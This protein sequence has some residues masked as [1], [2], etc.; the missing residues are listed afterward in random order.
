MNKLFVHASN[1]KGYEKFTGAGYK[2]ILTDRNW[3]DFGYYTLHE[4]FLIMPEGIDNIKLAD[5]RL[6]NFQQNNGDHPN[7]CIPNFVG[8][9]TQLEWAERILLFLSPKDREELL[10]DLHIKFSGKLYKDQQAF[11]KSV[12]RDITFELF[13]E[14]QTRIKSIV[15]IQEDISS[16]IERNK[17]IIKQL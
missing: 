4:L 16:M 10:S 17:D 13:E 3:N 2:Y 12:L 14:R 9:I 5:I 8:F 7:L 6:L 1:G 11:L 15:S